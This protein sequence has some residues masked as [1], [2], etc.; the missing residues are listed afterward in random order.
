MSGEGQEV[1]KYFERL[2]IA[3]LSINRIKELIKTHILNVLSCWE[4]GMEVQKQTFH[5]LGPA[6][7]G[8]TEIC[9]QIADELTKETG[10]LFS[11]IKIQ[12][13]VLSRDD[14]LIPFPVTRDGEQKFKML[15]SDFIPMDQESFGIYIIDE[16][17][18]GD[19]NLQ[20]LLWQVQNENKIH[21]Y[22]F[23]KGWFVISLDNPDDAEYSVD[24]LEDAAG[25]RRMLHLY[26]EVS[27]QDFLNH[28]I[29]SK[30]HSL[31]VEF[32][33]SH[34]DRLYDFDAQKRG[35]VYANPASYERVSNILWGYESRGGIS[36]AYTELDFLIS[37]LLNVNMTRLFM[38]F[39]R[40]RKDI[41]P[42][43]I[44]YDYEKVRKQV[45]EYVKSQNN[46]KLG[47]LMV[48][49]T[50]F[51]ST[52][53]PEY[54][55]KEQKNIVSF[56]TDIPI[57]TAALFVSQVDNFSRSSDEFR[58]ITKLHTDLMKLSERYR[59]DFYEPI[60]AVGKGN[61]AQ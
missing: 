14:F 56:L 37:G 25:L 2:N 16:F 27:P 1:Q 21:L 41:N 19:H 11:Q 44:L 24:Q 34:P 43:D 57:D 48:A 31:V 40:E 7:V 39:A 52:S 33:Q 15:Y 13:P 53:R 46:A 32:I 49:F 28:A 47:E 5:I 3:V 36:S 6:G 54:G 9:L 18:R 61:R 58:Y 8:K 30:F 60:V 10:K 17:S 12:C 42:R 20:Q 26:V 23:P 29:K 45:R 4:S 55:L 35:S 22:S 38:E 51:V 50:T 59:K